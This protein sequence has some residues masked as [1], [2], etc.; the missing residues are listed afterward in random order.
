M[1][2]QLVSNVKP[3]L[4]SR[5]TLS[6]CV[7]LPQS[8]CVCVHKGY[9]PVVLFSCNV[10]GL[11]TGAELASLSDSEGVSSYFLKES[12]CD[13][14]FSFNVR[15]H[16]WNH[17]DVEFSLWKD[18]IVVVRSGV[19]LLCRALR[20]LHLLESILLAASVFQGTV[21]ILS[22]FSN[23]LTVFMLSFSSVNFVVLQFTCDKPHPFQ[24][25]GR[26]NSDR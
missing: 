10:F 22:R 15:I 21:Y 7:T 23:L 16:H 14:V 25:K 4:L 3:T 18:V 19:C 11:S 17:L 20:C 13:T 6:C 1:P 2:P 12:L 5:Q 24:V 8:L 26:V 9:W